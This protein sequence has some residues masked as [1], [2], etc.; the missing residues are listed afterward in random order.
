M[1]VIHFAGQFLS[2]FLVYN[3]MVLRQAG[4]HIY[5]LKVWLTLQLMM[6]P[7]VWASPMNET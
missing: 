1:Q 3:R 2:N 4:K 5:S 7:D 6:C